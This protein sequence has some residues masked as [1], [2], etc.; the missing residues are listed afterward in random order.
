MTWFDCDNSGRVHIYPQTP[1][2]ERGRVYGG[3]SGSRDLVIAIL[4]RVKGRSPGAL[5]P[6]EGKLRLRFEKTRRSSKADRVT[7]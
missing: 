4:V 7:E 3:K 5:R 6:L 2:F 1:E